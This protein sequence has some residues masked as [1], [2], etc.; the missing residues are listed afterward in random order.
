MKSFNLIG[1]FP[2][3][4]MAQSAT[5]LRNITHTH[6]D[7]MH[8]LTPHAGVAS[9]SYYTAQRCKHTLIANKTELCVGV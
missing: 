5:T 4:T 9:L 2:M 1:A 8:S 6:M 3:V 7:R